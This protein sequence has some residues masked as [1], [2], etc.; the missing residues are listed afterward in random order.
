MMNEDEI[1][2]PH[3]IKQVLDAC[4][5]YLE[6]ILQSDNICSIDPSITKVSTKL[7]EQID[8]ASLELHKLLMA[9]EYANETIKSLY[10]RIQMGEE[11]DADV[12]AQIN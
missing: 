3:P 5:T 2:P 11:A 12:N 9:T 10:A 4:R 8:G 1:L 7:M 6:V